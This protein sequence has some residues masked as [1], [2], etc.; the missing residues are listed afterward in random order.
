MIVRAI[1]A[2]N[3]WLFGKGKS[4]YK[5]GRDAIA[6]EIKTR[7]QSFL[8]DCFFNLEAGINWWY[9]L[10]AK[11]IPAIATPVRSTILNTYG[12]ISLN[13]I[14]V[15][16]DSNRLLTLSYT[17]NTIYGTITNV[18]QINPVPGNKGL[19]ILQDG[20]FILLENSGFIQLE[21]D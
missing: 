12:I 3:D 11:S 6:Q 10:G 21:E 17:V 8:G 15:T 18:E 7:L 20:D 19:F 5:Y 2:Q 9:L 1:D 14:Q 4:D 16:L 13:Q